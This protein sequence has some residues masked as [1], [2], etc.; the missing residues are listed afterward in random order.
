MKITKKG[1]FDM[2]RDIIEIEVTR[3]DIKD[4]NILP[5]DDP[6]LSQQLMWL[7]TLAFWLEQKVAIDGETVPEEEDVA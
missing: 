4:F 1:D 3:M 7:T 5:P 6:R 2:T